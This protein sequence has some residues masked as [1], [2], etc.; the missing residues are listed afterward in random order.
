MGLVGGL[1]AITLQ[2]MLGT[3]LEVRTLALYLW[4]FAACVYVLAR[5][6]GVLK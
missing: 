1:A 4:L 5:Q 6:E 2:A 3:Y